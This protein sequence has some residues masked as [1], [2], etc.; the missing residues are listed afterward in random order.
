M[1]RNQ[2]DA[3]SL[4]PIRSVFNR[5]ISKVRQSYFNALIGSSLAAFNAGKI[6]TIIVIVIEHNEI[7]NIE[8]GF[9]SDGIVLRK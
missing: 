9:I 8:D 5:I 4:N 7:K 2:W 3:I 6:E 1:D